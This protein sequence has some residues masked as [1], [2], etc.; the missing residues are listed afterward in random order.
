[1]LDQNRGSYRFQLLFMAI[2]I[3]AT[4]KLIWFLADDRRPDLIKGMTGCF[5][6]P[7]NFNPTFVSFDKSGNL[8]IGQ[9][10]VRVTMKEDKQGL[11]LVA[12]TAIM[13]AEED[14]VPTLEL[15][16]EN[17][18][19]DVSPDLNSVGFVMNGGGKATYARVPCGLRNVS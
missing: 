16:G 11:L 17:N 12:D 6:G 13:L 7:A 15:A 19:I 14:Y 4:I 8:R 5:A 1:M 9:N 10:V 18:S 2:I 3:V